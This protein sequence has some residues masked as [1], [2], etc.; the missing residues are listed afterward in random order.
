[1][2][3][4][5]SNEGDFPDESCR[6]LLGA[7][8]IPTLLLD[9]QAT[10]VVFCNEAFARCLNVESRVTIGLPV[11]TFLAFDVL[12]S[13]AVQQQP[14]R[15]GAPWQVTAT[16]SSGQ[17]VLRLACMLWR[18][19]IGGK[20]VVQME[21][22]VQ[23]ENERHDL[24]TYQKWIHAVGHELKSPLT[25]VKGYAEILA[26]ELVS[27]GNPQVKTILDIVRR[28]S[29]RMHSYIE[30]MYRFSLAEINT[31]ECETTTVREMLDQVLNELKEDFTRH[32]VALDVEVSERVVHLPGSAVREALYQVLHSALV[33]TEPASSAILVREHDLGERTVLVVQHD[34]KAAAPRGRAHVERILDRSEKETTT[35]LGFEFARKILLEA[36]GE[37]F[38]E[39]GNNHFHTCYLVLPARVRE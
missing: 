2:D 19:T 12:P 39:A 33:V 26:H 23:G 22:V 7:S 17:G 9:A 35:T 25:S 10:C 36:G 34:A 1:M 37:A 20:N 14:A 30:D 15:Q 6:E 27:S 24:A 28:N 11:E 38:L 3:E 16:S 13:V 18:A 4:C 29:E 31:L 21:C 32:G 8:P 5:I